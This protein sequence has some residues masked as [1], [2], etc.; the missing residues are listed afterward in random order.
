MDGEVVIGTRLDTKSLEKD[1]NNSKKELQKYEKESEQLAKTKVKAE[2]DLQP[3]REEIKLIEKAHNEELKKTQTLEQQ[4]FVMETSQLQLDNLN[5]KYEKQIENLNEINKKIKNNA[6]SQEMVK[7]KIE[8]TSK[9]IKLANTFKDVGKGLENVI[10]KVTKWGLAV[11]SVRSAYNAIRGSISI[12]SQYNDDLATKIESIQVGLATL[13]EPIITRIVNW[14]YKLL[15]YINILTKAWF[16][17]DLFAHSQEE[18]LQGSVTQAK[19]LNKQTAGWDE[20]TILQDNRDTGTSGSG[21]NTFDP[22]KLNDN[23]VKAFEKFA[24]VMK[25]NWWWI[26][27]VGI[28]LGVVFGA[29]KIGKLL[30]NIGNLLGAKGIGGLTK[31]LS[32]IPTLIKIGIVLVGLKVIYDTIVNIKK[33]I[34]NMNKDIENI[35]KNGQKVYEENWKN[36]TDI[37]KLLNEQKRIREYMVGTI[38]ESYSWLHRITGLSEKDLKDARASA[39]LSKQT[40]DNLMEQYNNGELNSNKQK[41]VLNNFIEQYNYNLAL[42]DLLQKH[43]IETTELEEITAEYGDRIGIVANG[44]KISQEQLNGMINK[45][46]KENVLT[47]HIYKNI[48]D[49][50]KIK[51]NDKSAVYSVNMKV[52]TKE[53]A[54]SLVNLVKG[55]TD[56]ASSIVNKVIGNKFATGGITY[57]FASGGI[58]IPKPIKCAQGSIINQPGRGV[59]LTSAIGGEAGREGIIP[60]TDKQAMAELGAEIGRNVILNLTNITQLDN[61]Q[62]ARE[63]K[64]INAQNDFAY[65]R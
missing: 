39:I 29:A 42:L 25:D 19:E 37:N 52:N 33:D 18:A 31:A 59:P 6:I 21:G 61:R 45:S 15:G 35:R 8:E 55:I 22:P 38:G 5:K 63:Q 34:D 54:N 60:L 44:L 3:Y 16:D 41:E 40:A 50:N 48:D 10:K 13:L 56:T 4:K 11:F 64:R 23:L 49:I 17:L 14:I 28:A 30:G 43:G 24:K 58:T 9:Q 46:A 53:A 36:E 2:V 65:N 20:M 57:G 32:G 27:K 51:L 7:N 47:Q 62:I 26:E 12:L 1:L